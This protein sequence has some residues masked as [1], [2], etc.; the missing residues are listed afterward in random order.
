MVSEVEE[1]LWRVVDEAEDSPFKP[2]YIG[3]TGW[4]IDVDNPECAL[5]RGPRS[6]SGLYR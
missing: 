3:P 1:F 6:A 5:Q 2:K 4:T